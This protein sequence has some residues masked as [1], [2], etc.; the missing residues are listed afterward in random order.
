MRPSTILKTTFMALLAACVSGAGAG[1]LRQSFVS[2]DA[3]GGAVSVRLITTGPEGWTERWKLLE[4]AQERIDVTYYTLSKDVFGLA[5]L[6]RLLEAGERGVKVRLM[7]D[8]KGS[9]KNWVGVGLGQDL[10]QELAGKPGFVVKYYKTLTTGIA[11]FLKG[12]SML[13][14]GCGNHDKML[15]VDG[16]SAIAGGRNLSHEYFVAADEAELAFKDLD[17]VLEGGE[18]VQA[19]TDAFEREFHSR[20]VTRVKGERWNIK[21]RTKALKTI[22]RGMQRWLGGAP[23]DAATAEALRS[24]KA[25]RKQ[26]A[27]GILRDLEQE[28]PEGTVDTHLVKKA[29]REMAGY[30]SLRGALLK[31]HGNS[32]VTEAPTKVLDKTSMVGDGFNSLRAGRA[33]LMAEAKEEILLQ[34]PYLMLTEEQ[35]IN[36]ELAAERGVKVRILTNGIG[37]GDSGTVQAH[38]LLFWR[39]ILARL[40]GGELLV[41][42]GEWPM[43]TKAMVVDRKLAVLG[44]DNYDFFG[45]EVNGEVVCVLDSPEFAS[46]LAASWEADVANP[47]TKTKRYL[48]LRDAGGRVVRIPEGEPDAGRPV[49]VYGP[50]DHTD[51]SLWQKMFRKAMGRILELKAFEALMKPTHAFQS[52]TERL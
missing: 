36:L 38:F 34:T 20:A 21:K 15:L 43:H 22:A 26:V 50:E 13:T 10:F 12:G 37:T 14:T 44:S 23:F 4:S 46:Q 47:V 3:P 31:E 29:L 11:A 28:D 42:T 2:L 51:P 7:V 27:F 49:P 9:E 48:I 1:S 33:S 24:D 19:L 30:P 18:L 5:F 8:R 35:M 41:F 39:E 6:G 17:M 32:L 52:L 16:Q 45:S 40:P 25:V